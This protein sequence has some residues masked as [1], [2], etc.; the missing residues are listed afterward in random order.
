MMRVS[1]K[2]FGCRLN[3]AE[4]AGFKSVFEANGFDTVPF[5]EK[6]DIC[7]IHSCSVT[8]RAESESLRTARSVKRKHPDTFVALSGCAVE[9]VTAERLSD[10]KIDLIIPRHRKEQLVELILNNLNMNCSV[11]ST[12]PAPSFT[13]SRALLKIQDGCNFFCSYCIIPHNRGEPVSRNFSSCLDEAKTF[14]DQGFQEIVVTGC[15]IACYN[16]GGRR[17]PDILNAIASLPGIGRVRLGSLEP[18]M[19]ELEIVKLMTE[20][21]KICR[22]LHLPLQNC[23]DEILK[24]MKRRYLSGDMAR[25]IEQILETVPD[26]ALGTDIIT[27]FPGESD[28]QF[29]NTRNFIERYPFCNLHVFPYSER[30]GTA[31]VDFE[32]CVPHSIRKERAGELIAIGRRKREKYARSWTGKT[33]VVL[34]EKF[35]KAGKTCGWSGEYLPCRVSGVPEE[36]RNILLGRMMRFEVERV[37]GDVLIG[38]ASNFT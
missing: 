35:D 38:C 12:I 11:S 21:D 7:I 32:G 31:A 16:D 18:A 30:H 3:Q 13:T 26:I 5:R 23:D 25:I 4:T 9:S 37:D 8:Q 22:F 34:I 15:N 10:L 28:I 2:T 24:L 6:S 36:K 17:L 20:S 1:F 33:S 27:G 29:K 19:I 14:I